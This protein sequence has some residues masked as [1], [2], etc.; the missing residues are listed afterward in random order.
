MSV[1]KVIAPAEAEDGT[2]T[3]G[4]FIQLRSKEGDTSHHILTNFHVIK[5]PRLQQHLEPAPLQSICLPRGSTAHPVKVPSHFDSKV[6]LESLDKSIQTWH[7][8]VHDS[9]GGRPSCFDRAEM[10][11]K[12]AQWQVEDSKNR[13]EQHEKSKLE[14]LESSKRPAGAVRATSGYQH[15]GWNNKKLALDW[16]LVEVDSSRLLAYTLPSSPETVLVQKDFDVPS[17]ANDP[18][19]RWS[20][21]PQLSQE[22]VK[23]GRMTGWTCGRLGPA[24]C[25]WRSLAKDDHEVGEWYDR[26]GTV[27]E[28]LQVFGRFEEE[29]PHDSLRNPLL[30]AAGGDSGSVVK[31]FYTGAWV[32]LLF[33]AHRT[34]W[35]LMTPMAA[36]MHSIES[37]TGE[38]VVDPVAME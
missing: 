1:G 30:F 38:E 7:A 9:Y 37:V 11:D 16:A 26:Y 36:V 22:V 18:E 19:Q 3:V 35:A 31:D 5:T 13:I 32:G 29:K 27:V 15:I 8:K 21:S 24:T 25:F 34:G 4:G 6:M 17:W 23:L 10:G 20:R 12:G 2:G 28:C 33:C 14:I